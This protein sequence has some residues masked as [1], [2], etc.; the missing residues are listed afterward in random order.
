MMTLKRAKLQKEA[1]ADS[2]ILETLLIVVGIG[3]LGII[4]IKSNLQGGK[5]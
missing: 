5:L 3:V 1:D 4:I 2:K